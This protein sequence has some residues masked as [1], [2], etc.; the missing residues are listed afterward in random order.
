MSYNH[1]Y[2]TLPSQV[3]RDIGQS[4]FVWGDQP[5]QRTDVAGVVGKRIS[6]MMLFELSLK[7]FT[8]LGRETGRRVRGEGPTCTEA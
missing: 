6:E 8:Y 2:L 4:L 5:I 3:V 1:L 7:D